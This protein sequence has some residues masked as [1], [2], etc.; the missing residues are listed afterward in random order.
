MFNLFKKS[1]PG[2]KV[3]D[4]VCINIPAKHNALLAEW[5][6][7]KKIAFVFW[8]DD[9][10]R[11]ANDFFTSHSKESVTLIT[12]RQTTNVM[13]QE[14]TPVFAEHFPL[15]NKEIDIFQRL[16]LKEIMVYSSLDE[17][18]FQ[19]FGGEKI[20]SMMMKM[21]MKEDEVLEHRMITKAIQNAQEKI[22]EKV[23]IEQSA[24]SQQEWFRKNFST[25]V[26]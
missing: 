6:N 8:F 3:N 15:L 21:G 7:N 19:N 12:S 13:L 2:P 14:R 17:P 25:S 10:L 23:I 18:M 9:S 5:K 20:I 16:N 1:N 24:T 4:R 26:H 11:Q 22:A